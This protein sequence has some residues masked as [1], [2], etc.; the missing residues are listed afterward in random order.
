M[1]AT[2]SSLDT[3]MV[4]LTFDTATTALA[5]EMIVDAENE[6]NK[7]L[8]RRYDL[9][10]SYFATT[11]AI[12]PIVRSLTTRLAEAYMWKSGSRGG[13][14]SITRGEALEKS[15]MKNLEDIAAYKGEL[16]DTLGSIIPDKSNTAYRVLSNTQGY[17]P[18]FNEDKAESWRVDQDKLEDIRNERD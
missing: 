7:Y 6:V 8:A 4:G 5:A 3:R 10:S 1:Y 12:P 11:T 16:T 2:T 15:V 9:S 17:T 13:K 18:T 14:E